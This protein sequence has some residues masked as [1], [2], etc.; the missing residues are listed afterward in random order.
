MPVKKPY[1]RAV[2]RPTPAPTNLPFGARS[3]GHYRVPPDFRGGL[4]VK[5]C[6]WIIWGIEG[7]GALVINGVERKLGPRQIA[8]Y[9]PGMQ[10][11]VYALGS[12]WEYCFWTM[13]GPLAAAVTMAMG[14]AAGVYE[15][16]EAP[17][18]LF[19]L[20]GSAIRSQS[21]A[22]ERQASA[23]AY[24]LLVLAASGRQA[25]IR[26]RAVNEALRTIHY[27]WS[28][29][30]FGVKEL[31]DRLHLHR[32]S[33]SRRFEAAVGIPPVTYLSRLRVQNALS[34]LR[35]TD[36]PVAE[37]AALCGYED[38]N[39]FARMI[40]RYTGHAPRHFRNDASPE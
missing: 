8:V 1:F 2:Y 3:V 26:D 38:P 16:G 11:Q 20:L 24:R 31:A 6:V 34:M 40:R 17:V 15:A 19:R 35:H 14:L 25:D 23:L 12:P 18:S 39:Y 30:A 7:T 32:S 21:V 10:H 28:R 36:K 13:D 29:P 33:L 27:E 4:V 37:V 22:S 5:E 9:P